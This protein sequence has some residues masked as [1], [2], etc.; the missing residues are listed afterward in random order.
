MPTAPHPAQQFKKK[1]QLGSSGVWGTW[2]CG[3][4]PDQMGSGN[5]DLPHPT[6][7][8]PLPPG[9]TTVIC[10]NPVHHLWTRL[11]WGLLFLIVC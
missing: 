8:N 1:E 2:L 3:D 7:P 11:S 6:D 4:V 5:K 9:P 10:Y